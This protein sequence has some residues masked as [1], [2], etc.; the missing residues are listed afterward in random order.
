MKKVILVLTLFSFIACKSVKENPNEITITSKKEVVAND[1]ALVIDKIIS[2]SRCP[3]GTTCIW[4]GELV[5]K[6]SVWQNNALKET[7]QLTFSPTT[8]GENLA[9]FEKYIPQNKKLKS[10]RI[11]PTKTENQMELKDYKIQLILE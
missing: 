4:A 5:V 9:W 11:S 2:D 8:R 6:L 3:E 7:I 1:H 10:Y